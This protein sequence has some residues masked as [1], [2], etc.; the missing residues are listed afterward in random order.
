ML[1]KTLGSRAVDGL[2]NMSL[3]DE[4]WSCLKDRLSH[5]RMTNY[6]AKIGEQTNSTS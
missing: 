4:V 1:F 6:Q 2:M 5:H 3:M